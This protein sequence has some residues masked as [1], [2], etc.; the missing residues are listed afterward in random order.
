[1]PITLI[2]EIG[3]NMSE[4]FNL[5]KFLNEYPMYNQQSYTVSE[6]GKQNMEQQEIAKAQAAVNQGNFLELT[7]SQIGAGPRVVQQVK[8]TATNLL[9]DIFINPIVNYLKKYEKVFDGS[10]G[11][12]MQIYAKQMFYSRIELQGDI[13]QRPE[14]KNFII[15]A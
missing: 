2:Q 3:N 13:E 10:A 6:R 14:G 1:M 7:L 9:A 15:D 8:D 5:N 4:T 11:D 12:E